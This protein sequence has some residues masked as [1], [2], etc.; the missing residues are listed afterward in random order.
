MK[1]I[2]NFENSEYL[3]GYY[4]IMHNKFE[5]NIIYEIYKEV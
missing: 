4:V 2:K 1:Y 3:V 5:N